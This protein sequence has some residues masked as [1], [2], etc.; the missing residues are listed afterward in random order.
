MERNSKKSS[1]KRFLKHNHSAN[2]ALLKEADGLGVLQKALEDNDYI[3]VPDFELVNDDELHLQYINEQ[4]PT[5]QQS[6]DL[7]K[8]LALMHKKSYESCGYDK[9]NYIG[10]NPQKNILSKD[11][12]SFFVRYR[13]KYQ[14]SLIKNADVQ[15]SF[16]TLLQNNKSKLEEFLNEYIEH[17]SLVHGD[18]WSGNVLY[19]QDKVWLIDPAIYFGDREVDIA[20]S[21]MFGG[22]S[23]VFYES[24]ERAYPKSKVYE[25][26]K[27]IYNLYH[28]LNHYNLFGS[29][30]LSGCERGF[31]VVEGV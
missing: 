23:S 19:D 7:G 6:V 17:P 15:K 5:K 30:Y 3:S 11:W 13:L 24:Y 28:Y 16:L 26:K 8:G 25:I 14:L 27:V 4:S 18:L 10:L 2:D 31:E 20:M 22:F 21:E 1:I 9:D 29:G 12:G